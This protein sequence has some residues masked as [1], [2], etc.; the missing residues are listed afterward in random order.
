[1]QLYQFPFCPH[2]RFVRL[3]LGEYGIPFETVDEPV[4][5]RRP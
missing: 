4:W 3:V 1:M 2:S 5:K